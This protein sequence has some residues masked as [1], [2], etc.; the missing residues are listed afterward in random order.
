MMRSSSSPVSGFNKFLRAGKSVFWSYL[1]VALVLACFGPYKYQTFFVIATVLFG[2][3]I[4]IT[5]TGEVVENGRYEK[6]RVA[7]TMLVFIAI[8]TFVT[9]LNPSDPATHA[10]DD[11]GFWFANRFLY[12]FGLPFFMSPLVEPLLE[13]AKA[14]DIGIYIAG[15]LIFFA[16][17]FFYVARSQPCSSGTWYSS[18]ML[19]DDSLMSLG[20]GLLLTVFTIVAGKV[21]K[22]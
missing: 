10:F 17:I 15:A 6:R 12:L 7:F 8:N 13:S 4:L 11:S 21:E 19:A 16:F 20:I 3:Y 18:Q 1:L 22:F 14:K 9:L 2:V 5:R